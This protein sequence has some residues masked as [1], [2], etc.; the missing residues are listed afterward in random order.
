M[1]K[2]FLPAFMLIA[3]L[4]TTFSSC[5]EDKCENAT[6]YTQW[7]PVYKTDAEMRTPP[8]YQAARPLKN[9]GKIYFFD[10]YILINELKE[11]IHVIDKR[12]LFICR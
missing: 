1:K 8:Q 12:Q 11:G 6:T 7:N 4:A 9:T 5:L 2:T 10:H 3:L